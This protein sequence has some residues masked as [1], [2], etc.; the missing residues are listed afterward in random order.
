MN[1]ERAAL[2]RHEGQD[3]PARVPETDSAGRGRRQ[4][5]NEGA[6]LVNPAR[7]AL[8]GEGGDSNT[9]SRAPRDRPR[10]RTSRDQSPRRGSGRYSY[11]QRQPEGPHAGRL[12]DRS[13]APGSYRG[14]RPMEREP[15]RAPIDKVRDP[16]GFPRSGPADYDHRPP[17][18]DQNYGRLNPIQPGGEIPSGPR[19]RGRGSRAHGGPM[20]PGP[21]GRYPTGPANGPRPPSPDRPPERQPPTGPSGRHNGRRGYDPPTGPATPVSSANAVQPDRVRNLNTSSTSETPP[22]ASG[23]HPDRLAQLG[24]GGSRNAPP[25]GP[26]TGSMPSP[27]APERPR[28]DTRSASGSVPGPTPPEA[29][30]RGRAGGS[31]RQLAGINNMLQANKPEQGRSSSRRHQRTMLGN[32]DVQVLTGASPAST[33]GQER[34]DPMRHEAPSRGGANGEDAPR[35]DH[36]RGGRERSERHRSSRRSS[37]EREWSPGREKE[38]RDHRDRRSGAGPDGPGREERASR[39]SG[40]RGPDAKDPMAPP[41]PGGREPMGGREGRHRGGDGGPGEDW[42]HGGRPGRGGV[43]APKEG[44]YRQ[45]ERREDHRGRKRRSE[46]GAG[47]GIANEREKR[48]RR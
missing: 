33:P 42:G 38:Y 27:A 48:Q 14:E 28:N 11:D 41:P 37:R 25:T 30:E 21:D 10:D 35:E 5:Q 23:V 22:P 24:S 45:D 46:E 39:R 15:E 40:G 44:G 32:S 34:A 9:P 26:Q 20:G 36:D 17:Y 4:P 19:G 47:A 29:P 2:F 13:P 31:K 16:S 6:E 8:I 7:A 18:D 1:P 3:R 43:G 12:H